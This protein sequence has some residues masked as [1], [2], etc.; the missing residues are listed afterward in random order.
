MYT[1]FI[2]HWEF[3]KR[4]LEMSSQLFVTLYTPSIHPSAHKQL[5]RHL[6]NPFC[7]FPFIIKLISLISVQI[8]YKSSVQLHRY[9]TIFNYYDNRLLHKDILGKLQKKNLNGSAIKS[10]GGGT[11][12]AI[13]KKI[14]FLGC[15]FILLKNS[16]C[17]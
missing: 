4:V 2:S 16:D 6:P 17:H 14:T 11:A 10:G 15:F 1:D 12:L 9:H 5:R 13:K 3:T 8:E 7:E